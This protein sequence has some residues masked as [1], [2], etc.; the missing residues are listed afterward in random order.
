MNRELI[1]LDC[2]NIG[3]PLIDKKGSLMME[4][5]LWQLVIPGIIYSIW[6]RTASKRCSKCNS[7]NLITLSSALGQELMARHYEEKL[8]NDIKI[9]N[10][11]NIE[12]D[13]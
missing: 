8:A 11:N 6:R 5:L 7:K 4:I 13:C 9:K 12:R 10:E 2:E 1:C 3:Q